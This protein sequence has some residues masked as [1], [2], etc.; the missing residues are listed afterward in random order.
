MILVSLSRDRLSIAGHA[1]MAPKGEDIVCAAVSALGQALI[2]G[3][4]DILGIP[5]AVRTLE[6]GSLTA[7]WA[8]R[9]V[10]PEADAVIRTIRR[11]LE[12]IA[13]KHAAFL[14]IE[15]EK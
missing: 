8:S 7:E 9:D 2:V 12:E 1:G 13:K 4:R 11:S 10:G 6:P 15:P 5:V 14:T 3:L